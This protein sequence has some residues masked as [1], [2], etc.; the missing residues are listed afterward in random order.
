[1]ARL[2]LRSSYSLSL[3]SSNISDLLPYTADAKGKA[4]AWLSS[5][6]GALQQYV[7]EMK[8]CLCIY[9]I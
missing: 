3:S 9:D 7:S 5:K 6:Q 1:M 2:L 8:T 4:M